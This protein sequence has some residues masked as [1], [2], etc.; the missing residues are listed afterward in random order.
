VFDRPLTYLLVTLAS[1][2]VAWRVNAEASVQARPPQGGSVRL[3]C[4]IVDDPESPDP[5]YICQY[6][7]PQP[8]PP[9]TVFPARLSWGQEV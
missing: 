5:M 3:E 1:A 8:A 9:G 7:L 2:L 4:I 6:E